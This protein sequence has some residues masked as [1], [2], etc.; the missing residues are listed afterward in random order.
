[1]NTA[2]FRKGFFRAEDLISFDTEGNICVRG[3]AHDVLFHDEA[4]MPALELED[5]IL[6]CRSIKEVAILSNKREIVAC[7]ITRE[8]CEVTIDTLISYV[9]SQIVVYKN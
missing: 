2:S 3:N 1:M 4:V 7:I 6:K 5:T 9:N 8:D